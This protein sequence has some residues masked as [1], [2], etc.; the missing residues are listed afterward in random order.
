MEISRSGEGAHAWI[1]SAEVVPAYVA[2][3]MGASLLREA[4]SI[5]GTMSLAS[6]NRMPFMTSAARFCE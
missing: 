6:Y 5:R 3:S 1:F 2:R 4:M